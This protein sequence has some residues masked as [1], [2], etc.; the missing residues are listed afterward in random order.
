MSV[1]GARKAEEINAKYRNAMHGTESK[2]KAIIVNKAMSFC[3]KCG[4]YISH[5][6]SSCTK[7]VCKKEN[8]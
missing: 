8:T 2:K 3:Q 5:L 6:E 7:D 1:S 4:S